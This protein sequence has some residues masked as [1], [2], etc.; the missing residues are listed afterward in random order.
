[1]YIIVPPLVAKA[2]STLRLPATLLFESIVEE[3]KSNHAY[4]DSAEWLET[5]AKRCLQY[6]LGSGPRKIEPNKQLH[7]LLPFLKDSEVPNVTISFKRSEVYCM[8][9]FTAERYIPKRFV[10]CP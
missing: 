10:Y 9:K 3:L 1:M 8:P 2:L 5:I 6:R 4:H 7:A